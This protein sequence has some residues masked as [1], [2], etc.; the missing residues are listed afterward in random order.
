MTS[1]LQRK[2]NTTAQKVFLRDVGWEPRMTR[3]PAEVPSPNP[4]DISILM[5]NQDL[6]VVYSDGSGPMQGSPNWWGTII[7]G[8]KGGTLACEEDPTNY[9]FAFQDFPRHDGTPCLIYSETGD[10]TESNS[11]G[12]IHSNY[13]ER[14]L[15]PTDP[16]SN[17]EFKRVLSLNGEESF[18]VQELGGGEEEEEDVEI[19]FD[20]SASKS[21]KFTDK[22]ERMVA[23]R[24]RHYERQNLLDKHKKTREQR[25]HEESLQRELKLR[26]HEME[27]DMNEI[28]GQLTPRAITRRDRESSELARSSSNSPTDLAREYGSSASIALGD[29]TNRISHHRI[30]ASDPDVCSSS[31]MCSNGGFAMSNRLDYIATINSSNPESPLRCPQVLGESNNN[32]AATSTKQPKAT[33]PDES[34]TRDSIHPSGTSVASKTLQKAKL[35]RR[36]SHRRWSSYGT[37][38]TDTNIKKRASA[39][40]MDNG[41]PRIHAQQQPSNDED[42]MTFGIAAYTDF[43]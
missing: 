9:S 43:V 29:G 12:G 18:E 25:V 39:D 11:M 14:P 27:L 42:V 17:E 2:L 13:D 24:H 36:R 40:F 28:E 31:P 38:S 26:R 33:L 19:I 1:S 34:A 20:S 5:E 41:R 16:L 8:L 30:T 21:S 10:D 22:L 4:A 7:Q 3:M 32:D 6:E 35:G 23:M 15:S 37:E